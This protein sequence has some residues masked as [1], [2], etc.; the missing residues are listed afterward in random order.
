ML[1][2]FIIFT[3]PW[4]IIEYKYNEYAPLKKHTSIIINNKI[5]LQLNNTII[6]II[7]PI[8]FIDIGKEKFEEHNKNHQI[9]TAGIKLI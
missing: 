5:N 2:L 6:I 7:S 4:L 9:I 3:S 8:K 1:P